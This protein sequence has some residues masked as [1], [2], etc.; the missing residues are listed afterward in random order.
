MQSN[1]KTIG[2][3][4]FPAFTGERSYMAPFQRGVLPQSLS[5]WQPTVN[6]ML[7]G[8]T[9]PGEAFIM[10]S[11]KVVE[12]GSPHRLPGV[13][14]DGYWNPIKFKHQGTGHSGGKV[15]WDDFDFSGHEALFLASDVVGCDAWVGEIRGSI[16]NR[17]CGANLDLTNMERIRLKANTAYAG[18]VSMVHESIP[19]PVTTKRTLVR[20]N[21]PGVKL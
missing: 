8:I 3:V 12:G 9:V 18:H 13:H 7:H 11:Q 6:Q 20:I 5:R 17:G 14:V 15:G 1:I 2:P 10:I 19:I 4:T 21:V 16:G